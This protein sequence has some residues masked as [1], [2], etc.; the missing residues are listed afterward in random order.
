VDASFLRHADRTE[1]F[2]L[3]KRWRVGIRLIVCHASREEIRARLERRGA[4]ESDARWEVYVGSEKAWEPIGEAMAGEVIRVETT[5]S[6]EATLACAL[7]GLEAAGLA[8]VMESS[9][10]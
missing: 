4:G 2:E 3:A 6:P 8:E 10:V 7:E 5:G 1:F 9:M